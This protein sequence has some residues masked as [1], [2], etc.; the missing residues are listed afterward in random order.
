MTEKDEHEKQKE[1]SICENSLCTKNTTRQ[2]Y[3]VILRIYN[4]I[5]VTSINANFKH[6]E[7]EP[8]EKELKT[9]EK[10]KMDRIDLW[11][12]R[13][14]F[15][16]NIFGW[17]ISCPGK[18]KSYERVRG[19]GIPF[20]CIIWIDSLMSGLQAPGA[21]TAV[22]SERSFSQNKSSRCFCNNFWFVGQTNSVE[23]ILIKSQRKTSAIRSIA[24]TTQKH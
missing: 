17:S 23:L 13:T 5:L 10:N 4:R 2:I 11:L 3:L 18:L 12:N 24:E 9:N 21:S 15:D 19:N 20:K 6:I 8:E 1:K 22:R 14:E 7:T 16:R